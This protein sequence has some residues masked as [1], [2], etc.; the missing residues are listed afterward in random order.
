M[1]YT[2]IGAGIWVYIK[3]TIGISVSAVLLAYT[4]GGAAGTA[5]AVSRLAPK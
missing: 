1:T 3:T 2:S 4:F 5:F